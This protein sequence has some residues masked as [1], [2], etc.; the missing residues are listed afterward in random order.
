DDGWLCDRGRW[1]FG[2]VNSPDRLRTPLIRRKG[3]FEAA[4]WDEAFYYITNRLTQNILGKYGAKAVGGIGSTRTTN[5]EA[6]LFQKLMRD[7]IKTPN[8]DHHHGYFPGP[9][10][11]LTGKS[12][13][14]T[15]SIVDIEK[16]SHIVLIASDPY[17]RQPILNLRIKK[18][19]NA[20]AK[21]YIVNEGTTELDRFAALKINIPRDS[22]GA[23]AKVLLS[24]VVRQER[25]KVPVEELRTQ[26][27]LDD[28]AIRSHEEVFGLETTTNLRTLA[29]EIAEAEGAIL[30]YDEMAT[31]ALGCQNL[32]EDLQTLAYV[33]DNIDR[34]GAGVGPLVEDA[35]SLG[36]RDMGLLPDVLPGYKPAAE[37]GLSYDEMLNGSQIKALFV[38]GANPARHVEKLP[39][40]LEFLVVQDIVMTETAQQADVVLPAVTFAEK[41]GSMTNVDSHVQAV[42]QALRPLPGARADWEI[43]SGIAR[44]LGHNW[45]YSSPQDVLLEIAE[46]NSLYVGLDWIELGKQGVRILEREVAHA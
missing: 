4:T 11:K 33:T 32:A 17:E 18:A 2:Y 29:H 46:R 13:R 12:W 40:S 25:M 8:V 5:E 1:D 41:D 24:S 31:R 27:L 22:A 35:N 36:A 6:Y 44:M 28:A 42:R 3:Q 30:L 20:G 45:N 15:N 23:A 10:D 34:P 21:I 16:A 9:I 37:T 14:M 38:M 39:S 7:V 19:M 26:M 43:L